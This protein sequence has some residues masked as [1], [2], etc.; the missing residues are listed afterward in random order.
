VGAADVA[1]RKDVSWVDRRDLGQHVGAVD[2]E[3]IE[4]FAAA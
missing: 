1:V 2:V 3:V 4:Q